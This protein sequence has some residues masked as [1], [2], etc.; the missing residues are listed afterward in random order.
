[1]LAVDLGTTP[2]DEVAEVLHALEQRGTE[3]QPDPRI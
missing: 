1:V 2:A 3:S